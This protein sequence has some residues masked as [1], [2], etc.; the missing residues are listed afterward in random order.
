MYRFLL[1]FFAGLPRRVV[2]VWGSEMLHPPAMRAGDRAAPRPRARP[3]HA[4]RRRRVAETLVL[5]GARYGE[6]DGC[7]QIQQVTLY[8]VASFGMH[9]SSLGSAVAGTQS[10]SLPSAQSA[11]E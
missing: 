1:V 10:S 6:G 5:S 3:P 11:V 2:S 8:V 4:A 9:S 7:R